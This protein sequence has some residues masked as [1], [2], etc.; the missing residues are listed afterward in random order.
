MHRLGSGP[1]DAAE[2][3]RHPFFSGIDWERLKQRQL[4]APFKPHTTAATDL[5]NIDPVSFRWLIALAF[6]E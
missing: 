2:I 1:G 5:R 4:A 3:K 6:Q